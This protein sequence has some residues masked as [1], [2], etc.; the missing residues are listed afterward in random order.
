M[1][2]VEIA[3]SVVQKFER[4]HTKT[5]RRLAPECMVLLK[6]NGDFPLGGPCTIALYGPGARRTIK[7][8]TGSGD[9]NVRHFS[10][11]EEGL[12][13][14]GF[15]ITTKAWLDA[16]DEV[17]AEGRDAFLAEIMEQAEREGKSPF[18]V[19]LGKTPAEPRYS[20][21]MDGAGGVCVYVLSR[22]SG[23]GADRSDGKGDLLLSDDEIRD[24]L[25]CAQ[26]YRKF[27]LVLNVGG[28]VD[29]SPVLDQVENILLLSQLGTVTGDA[30]A[31][32]LLGKAYPSGKLTT[33]WAKAEDYQKIGDFGQR[34]DTRYREG[35]YVGYRYFDAAGIQ[36]IYPF[37]YGLSYTDFE[38]KAENIRLEGRKVQV[39]V[40]VTN[41][42]SFAGKETAL[43]YYSAP[44]GKLDKPVRELGAYAKTRELLPGESE[45]LMLELSAENMV[46]WDSENAVWLMEQGAYVLSVGNEPVGIVSLDKDAVTEGLSHLDGGADFTD[47]KPKC[48]RSVPAGLPIVQLHAS[49]LEKAGHYDSDRIEGYLPPLPDLTDFTDSELA[50]I[51]VGK[52]VGAA[53]IESV[54]GSSEF[55][56]IGAGAETANVVTDKGYDRMVMADG[57]AGIRVTT[58]YIKTK[59]GPRGLDNGSLE[60]YLPLLGEPIVSLLRAKRAE[61]NEMA[62]SQPIYYHYASAIPIGTALAQSWNLEL[63]QTCGDIVGEEMD[64]FGI[65][66]WLAPAM[67]IHRSPLCGRNFEYYSEDPYV[68]GKTAAAVTTGVQSR[69]YCAVTIKHFACNNQ[70]TNRFNSNSIVSERA[71]R[72]IY[73][74]GFEICVKEAAPIALMSSYNLL[75]GIHMANRHDLLTDVLR[76][77]WG[78]MGFVMTDWNTTTTQQDPNGKYGPASDALCIKAGNDQIMPGCDADVEGILAALE[79]GV[80]DRSELELSA[81]RILATSKL[82]SMNS[83]GGQKNA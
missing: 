21:S 30:F 25:N 63:A 9:V 79:S 36:P 49:D 55:T 57:P 73:L 17:K 59:N 72:E 81:G 52:H 6:K 26:K 15:T 41:T 22:V 29:L 33:T 16:Y 64:L 68:S 28:V 11:V 60:E 13:N 38:V 4:E 51:C 56:V 65:N 67:N 75:G 10:S 37:G 47:W 44:N 20:F 42:G 3:T 2:A 23:E 53:S 69:N 71:L 58:R 40:R 1:G 18:L 83:G 31:D 45:T 8:G 76:N 39:D 54:I 70:E 50:Q 48:Q 82:L 19:G 66:V 12:E 77:E 80:L 35:I 24:I 61:T 5:L 27:L 14:A 46:S 78:F 74:K 32:V 43:L 7:G 34:D 62:K